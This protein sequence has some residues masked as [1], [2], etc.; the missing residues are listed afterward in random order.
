MRRK[1][2]DYPER[3]LPSQPNVRTPR[4]QP[5]EGLLSDF[6]SEYISLSEITFHIG[7]RGGGV[8]PPTTRESKIRVGLLDRNKRRRHQCQ[9]PFCATDLLKIRLCWCP[10]KDNAT[11]RFTQLEPLEFL[12]TQLRPRTLRCKEKAAYGMSR[13][14]CFPGCRVDQ[15]KPI[16]LYFCCGNLRHIPKSVQHVT[17]RTSAAIHPLNSTQKSIRLP[18]PSV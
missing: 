14:R 2:L 13:M 4:Q 10:D 7:G 12:F 11:R 3:V 15:L 18:F 1:P 5:P 17:P 8:F 9:A 6:R 16:T